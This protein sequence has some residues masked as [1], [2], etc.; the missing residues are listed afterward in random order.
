M[1]SKEQ[2][3]PARAEAVA[4]LLA[5]W[6][7]PVRIQTVPLAEAL[8]RVCAGDLFSRNTLPV[9]RSSQ[10]D[11]IGVRFDDLKD[12]VPDSGWE[13]GRDY[14][15][16]D[17]GDDFEDGFD[18]VIQV[19][20]LRF[21]ADGRLA[22][23]CPEEPVRRGQ[24]ISTRGATLREGELLLRAGTVLQ[25]FHLCLLASAGVTELPVLH[26]PTAAYIPTGSELVP[27]G[28]VPGRGQNVQ[29]NGLMVEA[30]LRQWG[31]EARSWP[32][33]R[34]DEAA[35]D[36][37]LSD[38]LRQADIVLMNG[39]SSRGGEDFTVKLL[40]RRAS[41]LQHGVSCIPGIPVALAM[42]ENT[43][44]VN[45]PGPPFAAFC[46]LDWAVRPLVFRML[47]REPPA[48]PKVRVR[49]LEPVRKPV[50]YEFYLRL[51]VADGP[52]GRTARPLGWDCR[53]AEAVSACNALLV[54]PA[55]C[56][57]YDAGGL[58][59]AEL[60]YGMEGIANAPASHA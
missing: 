39:G 52:E 24:L 40:E 32:I 53:F 41:F 45:L 57:G 18:T 30:Y 13:A 23:I 14:V 42:V 50:G 15:P 54:L 1:A 43:P 2:A 21:S 7:P 4:A 29:S 47:G 5:R 35:L 6:T 56:G 10:A 37:A 16:A 11:G 55:G 60:L 36:A 9:C 34:D 8:G 12:G 38:A 33:V 28:T 17:T 31:A 25:P 58:V 27:V 49:L 22:E 59:E 46:A 26:R 20:D 51:E 3:Y 48:R 44:V 19:E